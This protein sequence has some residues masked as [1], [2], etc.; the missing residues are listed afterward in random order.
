[1]AGGVNGGAGEGQPCAGVAAVQQ[2]A[3]LAGG[4]NGGVRIFF[5]LG[6]AS[7]GGLQIRNHYPNQ[8]GDSSQ[9]LC[10]QYYR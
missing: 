6:I 10:Y 7:R 9:F 2:A 5:F 8:C 1:M 3:G 4:V